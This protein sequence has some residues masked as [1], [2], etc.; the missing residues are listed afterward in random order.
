MA[1]KPDIVIIRGDHRNEI[2]AFQ[3]APE[4][5]ARLQEMGHTVKVETVPRE[6]SMMG[7]MLQVDPSKRNWKNTPDVLNAMIKAQDDWY[8]KTAERY[9]GATIV[10]FHNELGA[11]NEPSP[12]M[13]G[14]NEL[15]GFLEKREKA[16]ITFS[17]YGS[18]R[19]F[20]TYL[21]IPAVYK[22][23]KAKVVNESHFPLEVGVSFRGH[24]RVDLEWS[25]NLGWAGKEMVQALAETVADIKIRGLGFG[26]RAIRTN[27]KAYRQMKRQL[28][29]R[30]RI[31]SGIQPAEPWPKRER[32]ATET[33]T[34]KGWFRLRRARA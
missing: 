31:E 9:G 34:R 1:E 13:D 16:R 19:G 10:D 32:S 8:K 20:I 5:A 22:P 26:S 14:V 30:I 15:R 33:K 7:Y 6:I 24:H 12:I 2:T 23:I 27:M 21:E 28:A 25:Q 3:L 17:K 4:V 29:K 11:F 18:E